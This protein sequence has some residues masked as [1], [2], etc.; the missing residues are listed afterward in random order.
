MQIVEVLAPVLGAR[1]LVL[2]ADDG[3]CVVVD[4]GA[5]VADRV[6]A[7]VRERG[8]RPQAVL[9]THGH[10]DHTW[11]AG[12]LSARWGV[13]V[14]L[15]AG[16]VYRLADPF[17]SLGVLGRGLA[18]AVSEATSPLGQALVASG[19]DPAGYVA[20]V[21][22]EPFGGGAAS[23]SG[24][25]A[26]VTL[27]W[28]ALRIVARHAPGHTEGSTVYLLDDEGRAEGEVS[29]A[30]TGDVLFAGSVGRTD[31]PGGDPAA[32]ART[33]REVVAVLPRGAVVLPGHGPASD[34]ASELTHNPYLG[35]G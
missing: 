10:L 19:I 20:P 24:R 23:A 30:I 22:V 4:A 27:T 35:N 11:D 15:H 12:V 14:V 32:M 7:L 13:P 2:A 25:S 8:W 1:C 29:L 28:G 17:G 33:L 34:V 26:D 3:V 6:E 16:D 5:G 31:L 9:A 18:G 21:R